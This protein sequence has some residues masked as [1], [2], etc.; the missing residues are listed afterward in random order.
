ML[1]LIFIFSITIIEIKAAAPNK[2][3]GLLKSPSCTST[4]GLS[5]VRP[6]NWNPISA[7]NNPIPAPIPSFKL[8]GIEFISHAL[9]GVSETIKNTTPAT[10]TAPSA[11]AGVYFI[12]KQTP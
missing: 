2:V 7:K 10:N 12:P 4:T 3:K 8:F 1:P 6:I 9:S 5:E 11:S